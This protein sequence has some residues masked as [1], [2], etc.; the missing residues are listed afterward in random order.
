MPHLYSDFKLEQ[1][2]LQSIAHV[3]MLELVVRM[4]KKSRA[5][6]QAGVSWQD[7]E[8]LVAETDPAG[9]TVLSLIRSEAL[10]YAAEFRGSKLALLYCCK[11]KVRKQSAVSAATPKPKEASEQPVRSPSPTAWT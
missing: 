10:R 5:D 7:V 3:R 6:R 2:E 4:I 1:E 11:V 9:R 8:R